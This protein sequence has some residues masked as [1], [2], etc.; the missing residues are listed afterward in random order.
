[1]SMAESMRE[2]TK[3]NVNMIESMKKIESIVMRKMRKVRD[4]KKSD[5]MGSIMGST[6]VNITES[7][8]VDTKGGST[9]E[10]IAESID[11]ST[12]ST[13]MRNSKKTATG[14]MHGRRMTSTMKAG[15][16]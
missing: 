15:Y 14:M 8:T 11:A 7:T 13:P 10:G 1:M 6:T 3:M 4:T 12:E 9:T 16:S 2:S 5:I